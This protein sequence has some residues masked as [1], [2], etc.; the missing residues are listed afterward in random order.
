MALKRHGQCD[1]R[2]HIRR[3]VTACDREF[4]TCDE[5]DPAGKIILD[6]WCQRDASAAATGCVHW[7]AY[8]VCSVQAGTS[9]VVLHQIQ[10]QH[11][12][13]GQTVLDAES[14]VRREAWISMA[15][16]TLTAPIHTNVLDRHVGHGFEG[17]T[18]NLKRIG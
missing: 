11:P 15:L 3:R 6:R 17:V 4:D 12:T 16:E 5:A 13:L 10:S 14:P 18:Q 7:I 2:G 9:G 1:L 8:H